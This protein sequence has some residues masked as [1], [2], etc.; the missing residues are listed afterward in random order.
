MCFSCISGL[1]EEVLL[2]LMFLPLL[3]GAGGLVPTSLLHLHLPLLLM[4]TPA[5]SR[6]KKNKDYSVASNI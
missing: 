2:C 4:F 1:S 3:S 5:Q 6:G